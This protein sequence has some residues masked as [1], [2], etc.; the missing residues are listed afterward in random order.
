MAAECAPDLANVRRDY[1]DGLE[2]LHEMAPRLR[3]SGKQASLGEA[4]W[5]NFF[6]AYQGLEDRAPQTRF[7]ELQKRVLEPVVPELFVPRAPRSGLSP[8]SRAT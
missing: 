1:V 4:S 2:R 8:A 5:T 6:L 7:G 3:F